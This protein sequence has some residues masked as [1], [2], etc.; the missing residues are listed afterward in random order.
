MYKARCPE[1]RQALLL[2][3]E[4]RIHSKRLVL[5]SILVPSL[6]PEQRMGVAVCSVFTYLSHHFFFNGSLVKPRCFSDSGESCLSFWGKSKRRVTG[7]IAILY[8]INNMQGVTGVANVTVLNIHVNAVMR[9]IFLLRAFTGHFVGQRRHV[10]DH[11]VRSHH[12]P[13]ML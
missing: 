3:K 13:E 11:V 8:N 7:F 5:I 6:P 2:G 10:S 12:P 1:S 9:L 4:I